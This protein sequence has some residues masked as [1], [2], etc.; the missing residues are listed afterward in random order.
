MDRYEKAAILEWWANPSTCLVQVPARLTATANTAEWEAVISPR[1]DHGA[2][3]DLKQL[4]DAD[5]CFT[6]RLDT[7]AV[8]VQAEGFDDLDHLR[9]AVILG[10]KSPSSPT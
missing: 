1:L 2:R 10:P 7:S 8:E 6:L 9:L 5:P 4:I 3:D